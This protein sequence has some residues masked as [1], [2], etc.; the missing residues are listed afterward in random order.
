MKKRGLVLKQ[1]KSGRLSKFAA[2]I[3]FLDTTTSLPKKIKPNLDLLT[4][5]LK[6]KINNVGFAF[7]IGQNK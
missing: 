4:I 5:A 3:F 1:L 2:K 6:I 7:D